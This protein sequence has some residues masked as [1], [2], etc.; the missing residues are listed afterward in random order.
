MAAITAKCIEQD[1]SKEYVKHVV[2]LDDGKTI[3]VIAKDPE[4]AIKVLLL[5]RVLQCDN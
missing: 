2:T 3:E 1:D 5:K 4:D